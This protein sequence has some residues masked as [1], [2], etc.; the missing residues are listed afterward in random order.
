MGAQPTA[1]PLNAYIRTQGTIC[2]VIN[3]VVNP[4]LAWLSNREKEFVPL[5]GGMI[6]DTALTSLV[7]TLLVSLFTSAGVR[8]ELKAGRLSASEPIPFA[9]PLLRRLPG[10]AWALGLTLG[11]GA[12]L[13]LPVLVIGLFGVLQFSGLSF[14]AFAVLKAVY[15]GLLAYAVTRCVILRQLWREP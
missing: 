1:Q 14:A 15:T 12:M 4:A 10:G 9:A 5:W 3:M 2:A 13:T 6:I 11:F 8:R 7:L